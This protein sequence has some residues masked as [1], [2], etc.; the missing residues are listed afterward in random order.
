VGLRVGVDGAALKC[1]GSRL[2]RH[3]E[4]VASH[5]SGRF[6]LD[7]RQEGRVRPDG[8]ARKGR[9]EIA[10]AKEIHTPQPG[11]LDRDRRRASELPFETDAGLN[12]LPGRKIPCELV[13]V[14][15]VYGYRSSG[16]GVR[17]RRIGD[18]ESAGPAAVEHQ[19]M[20]DTTLAEVF[21]EDT[22]T[23]PYGRRLLG[24]RERKRDPGC[25]VVR[26]VEVR[27]RI[28]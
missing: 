24:G 3:V 20:L 16:K 14:G 2:E 9:V 5:S 12:E 1:T 13:T 15:S 6:N 4:R 23:S 17:V 10:H 18:D 28:V 7:D 8:G 25:D 21:I 26:I 19:G 27:L 11:V 22:D